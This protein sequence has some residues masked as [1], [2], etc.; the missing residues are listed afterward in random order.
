VCVVVSVF[1]SVFV[2]V[3]LYL[4]V[5]LCL[6]VSMCICICV[7]EQALVMMSM[8]AS[9]SGNL[10]YEHCVN[11]HTRS[12]FGSSGAPV[13]L[14]ALGALG[15]SVPSPCPRCA[16]RCRPPLRVH[17]RMPR[18]LPHLPRLLPHLP[19][20]SEEPT[21]RIRR[22]RPRPDGSRSDSNT[23]RNGSVHQPS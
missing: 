4:C 10:L 17:P 20:C 13:A 1:V 22:G 19:S 18:L 6:C 14:G 8:N 16:S 15:A 3:C 21:N 12:H 23:A 11:I 7:S 5:C 2:C 9:N